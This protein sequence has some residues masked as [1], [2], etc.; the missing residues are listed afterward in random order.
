MIIRPFDRLPRWCAAMLA[1]AALV[2]ANPRPAT[3]AIGLDLTYVDTNGVAYQRFRDWVDLTLGNP[4]NPQYGFSATDAAYMYR[5]TNNVAYAQLA[6]STAEAQVS[7]A[8]SAIA[9]GV[10]PEI[11]GDSYLHVGEMLRDVAVVY[12][13]CNALLTPQ[14]RTRWAAYAQQAVWNVW[15]YEQA[16][17]GGNAFPWSGWE[18]RQPGQQLPLQFSRG[19]DVLGAG[20][21]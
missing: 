15:N 8:E 16:S 17:W 21:E 19:D 1:L 10:R 18:R 9:L 11:A 4:G 2:A 5:L 7:A 20:E 12:D 6:I 3:A 13:W 14:Q